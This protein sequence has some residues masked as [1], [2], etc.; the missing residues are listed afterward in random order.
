[1]HTGQ[2]TLGK[3]VESFE[4]NFT[5][6]LGMKY[7]VAVSSATAGLH[8]ALLSLD[9]KQGDEVIVPAKTFISTANAASYCNA[10]PVFCDVDDDTFQ[11]DPAKLANLI[12]KR[13]KAI[14]PV[15]IAGNV[16]QMDEILEIS[17]KKGIPIV[18]DAAHAHGATQRKKKAGTFGDIGVFS[19][20]PDKIMA[21][22][23]GGILV[24]NNQK[25]FEK[26]ILY[27]NVGRPLIG[28][29]DFSVIGYNYR[30]NEIQA[31]IAQEQLRLLPLMLKKRRNIAKTYDENFF[32]LENIQKQKILPEVISAYYAYVLR[33][34]KGNLDNL[35]NKL[36]KKGIQ[37]SPMFTTLYKAK[38]YSKMKIQKCYVSEKL[39][40]QTFS[41]PLHPNLSETQIDFVS[42]SLITLVSSNK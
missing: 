33:L 13:T 11:I 21:S 12:T 27:R 2:L 16:C 42:K 22:S 35:R 38:P 18:E 34:D 14:I 8:V 15:H 7:G 19:F 9:I 32:K 26:A 28:K 36:S 23:D 40:S 41:I 20:Y 17:D 1:L 10:K 3:N 6:F 30:M 4:D 31:I 39:D 29:Y 37:T 24:T 25:I 5:R